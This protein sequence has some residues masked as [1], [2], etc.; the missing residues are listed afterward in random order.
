MYLL[1]FRGHVSK[2]LFMCTGSSTFYVF[3]HFF[4]NKETALFIS[5]SMHI[6]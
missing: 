5:M 4:V 6:E 3:G 2:F 1:Q